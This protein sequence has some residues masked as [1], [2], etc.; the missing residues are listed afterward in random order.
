MLETGEKYILNESNFAYI[1]G[2]ILL[3]AF[4]VVPLRFQKSSL[5]ML[6]I[7]EVQSYDP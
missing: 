7:L 5:L 1:N 4:N 3:F 6:V 2:F